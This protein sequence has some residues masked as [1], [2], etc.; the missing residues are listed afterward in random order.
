M[1]SIFTLKLL[2]R[3]SIEKLYTIYLKP[4]VIYR[5]KI[6]ATVRGVY[7]TFLIFEGKISRTI[8]CPV[9]FNDNE[10]K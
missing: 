3:N 2:P 10:K 4:I 9:L 1:T 6:W 5:Y 8:Y 7:N